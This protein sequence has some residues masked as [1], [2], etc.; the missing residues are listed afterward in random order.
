M[1][2]TTETD[3][4]NLL[5]ISGEMESFT[6]VTLTEDDKDDKDDKDKKDKK[7]IVAEG[8]LPDVASTLKSQDEVDDLLSNLG[9]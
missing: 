9:F 2:E 1:L 5:S 6:G 4:V 7:D 3:L 8:P